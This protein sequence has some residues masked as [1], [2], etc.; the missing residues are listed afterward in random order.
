MHSFEI[1][2]LLFQ[3]QLVSFQQFSGNRGQKFFALN[4]GISQRAPL[5]FLQRENLFVNHAA[6]AFRNFQ[7]HLRKR[8]R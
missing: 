6:D 5:W 4:A 3:I 2:K 1:G 8:P 7:V